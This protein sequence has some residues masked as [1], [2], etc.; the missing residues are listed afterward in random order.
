MVGLLVDQ[1]QGSILNLFK[2][3]TDV[4]PDDSDTE[5]DDAGQHEHEHRE[6]GVP[7]DG[8]FG[9]GEVIDDFEGRDSQPNQGDHEAG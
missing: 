1:K 2:D 3:P 9:L 4:Q 6:T 7:G 8:L 5:D